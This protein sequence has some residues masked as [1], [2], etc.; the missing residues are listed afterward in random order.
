M[1]VGDYAGG[2]QFLSA[3]NESETFKKDKINFSLL[4]CIGRCSINNF[5][6]D[7]DI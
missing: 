1:V 3:C 2:V 5:F 4:D 6:L 7:N